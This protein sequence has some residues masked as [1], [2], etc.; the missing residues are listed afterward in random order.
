MEHKA[1]FKT[2]KDIK[3][4]HK[5]PHIIYKNDPNW[6]PHLENDIENKFHKKTNKYYNGNNAKRWILKTNDGK[7]AGR[8]AAWVHPKYFKQFKQKTEE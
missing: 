1:R 6:I 3:D 7:P 5:V 4:F 8:I 2:K